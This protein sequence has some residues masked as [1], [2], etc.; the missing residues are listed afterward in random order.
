MGSGLPYTRSSARYSNRIY[1]GEREPM[2]LTIDLNIAKD[3]KIAGLNLSPY[4]KI[5]NL[6]DRKNTKDVYD[7]SGSAEFD[8]DMNF[9]TYRGIKTQE[10]FYTRPDFYYAPRKILIGFALGFGGPS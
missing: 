10:E 9:Q 5:T 7:S 1:N 2:T 8:Y 4:L 6:L 3:V